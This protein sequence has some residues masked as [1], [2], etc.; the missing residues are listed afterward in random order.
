MEVC[1]G[2][3]WLLVIDPARDPYIALVGGS[4]WAVELTRQ[5][6]E[7]LWRASRR[8]RMQHAALTDQ[9][10]AEES[11]ELDLELPLQTSSVPAASLWMALEGD[12][13]QWILRFVLNP[14]AGARAVEG[15]WSVGASAPFA[16]A[17][18]ALEVRLGLVD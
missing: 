11:L 7:T 4:D 2:E 12:R 5:E 17:L 14:G 15:G 13:Q 1:Q 6:L 16:A 3:G 10:M 18:E 8:L 9:L